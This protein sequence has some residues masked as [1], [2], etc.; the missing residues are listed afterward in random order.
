M[1]KD[2]SIRSI[3]RALAILGSFHENRKKMTLMEIATELELNKSTTY[4]I[5]TNLTDLGFLEINSDGQ[6]TVGSELARLGN[7][8]DNDKLLK[9]ATRAAMQE[10]EEITGET[11]V[12]TRYQ[13]GRMTCIDRIESEKALRITSII[14]SNIPMMRG[15][16][17]KVVTSYLRETE[18]EFC[19]TRQRQLGCPIP[20]NLQLFRAQLK[21]VREQG[22][23]VTDSELD[24]DV[25]ALAFPLL[26]DRQDPLGSIS[27]CGPSIRFTRK[28][29]ESIVQEAMKIVRGV[30]E[31]IKYL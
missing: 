4:R 28:Q 6:Y 15:A 1:Q 3:R 21:Q 14:G 24:E 20:E 27:V 19:L 31:H 25:T 17:G 23:C 22:Y 12:L 18:L 5:L 10:L 9:Q 13:H 29:I 7:L 26:R 16:T 8:C 11:V 30:E 2:Y